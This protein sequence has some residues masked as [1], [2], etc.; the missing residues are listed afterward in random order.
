MPYISKATR[1][2]AQQREQWM[3]LAE[4]VAHVRNHDECNRAE[5]LKQLSE[6]L[7]DRQI[8]VRWPDEDAREA[9]AQQCPAEV[10]ISRQDKEHFAAFRAKSE[11]QR[12]ALL[13]ERYTDEGIEAITRLAYRKSMALD[14]AAAVFEIGHPPPPLAGSTVGPPPIDWTQILYVPALWRETRYRG[15]KVFDLTCDRW[16]MP[17]LDRSSVLRVWPTAKP[18][19]PPTPGPKAPQGDV[20]NLIDFG[21]A[22]RKVHGRDYRE[23]DAPLIERMHH[24]V[25]SGEASN[26]WDAAL[27][28]SDEAK[29][30]GDPQS[31][32]KRLLSRYAEQFGSDGG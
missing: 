8:P 23:D 17:L 24:M 11:A 12:A 20:T 14:L 19:G 15:G 3:A 13:A 9:L 21:R 31:K 16:R 10:K 32:A 2:R 18:D 26:R 4:A 27:R 22:K 29:G 6:A 1:I 30:Y 28:L 7:A 5:A 25:Q